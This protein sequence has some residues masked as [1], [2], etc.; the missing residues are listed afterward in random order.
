MLEI[1]AFCLLAA[2]GI[3]SVVEQVPSNQRIDCLPKP[4]GDKDTC[5]F[6]KCIWDDEHYSVCLLMFYIL[7]LNYPVIV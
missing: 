7:R 3:E 4:G 2:N 6:H 5:L 1:I